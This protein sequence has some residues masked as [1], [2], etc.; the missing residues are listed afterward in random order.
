MQDLIH[1]PLQ[2]LV[3]PALGAL[4]LMLLAGCSEDPNAPTPAAST[5]TTT[6]QESTSDAMPTPQ[7]PA[8]TTSTTETTETHTV[9]PP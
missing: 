6:T 8:G 1:H 4:A 3:L 9:S 7:A 2:T 5:T